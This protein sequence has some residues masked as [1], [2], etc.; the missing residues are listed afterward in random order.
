MYYNERM[1]LTLTT[2]LCR[3]RSINYDGLM[4]HKINVQKLTQS[5]L[6]RFYLLTSR[7]F[8]T[9]CGASLRKLILNH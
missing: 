4:V 2:N 5:A 9:L 6:T 3:P 8:E 7:M 1:M